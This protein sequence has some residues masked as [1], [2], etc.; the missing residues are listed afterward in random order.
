MKRRQPVY[1]NGEEPLTTEE[2]E[3]IL[4]SRGYD[5][6][7][8]GKRMDTVA[9]QAL[10][11]VQLETCDLCDAKAEYR[12]CQQCMNDKLVGSHT[13][14]QYAALLEELENGL[15]IMCH[16][17]RVTNPQHATC[18]WCGDTDSW[19]KAIRKAKEKR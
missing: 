13:D 16:A 15:D 2:A 17:C 1:I 7:A 4:R 14:E 10:K 12:Q 19:R 11:I 5:P 8:V 18:T 6:D 9:K 3:T